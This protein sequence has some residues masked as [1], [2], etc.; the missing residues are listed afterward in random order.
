MIKVNAQNGIAEVSINGSRLEI[1]NEWAEVTSG[2]IKQFAQKEG[3][4][5]AMVAAVFIT[6]L[7]GKV[8]NGNEPQEAK[9]TNIEELLRRNEQ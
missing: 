6:E 4:K 1:I 9:I 7:F 2:L 3:V 8:E 5:P